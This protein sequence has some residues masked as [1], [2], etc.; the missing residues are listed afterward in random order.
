MELFRT[1]SPNGGSI[2][3]LEETRPPQFERHAYIVSPHT[4]TSLSPVQW[5]NP[6]AFDPSR[7]LG[8]PTSQD[9]DQARINQIGL[10]KCPF[11]LTSF[12]VKD[13]RKASLRNSG[14]GT[15]F[16][17]AD[18]KPLPVCDYAG[19]APFGFGYRR[20]PGEQLTIM[21]FEDLLRKVWREKIDFVK[22]AGE[23]C[24]G[25][26]RRRHV[27]GAADRPGHGHSRRSRLRPSG[28]TRAA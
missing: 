1:I 24:G 6:D 7:Y 19:F 22:M 13:G 20:C 12:D 26:D 9:V 28:L 16:G 25:A 8:K 11:D 18:G 3:A 14:W 17:V 23:G 5:A 15:V 10:A 21:V 4:S 2:S 27:R